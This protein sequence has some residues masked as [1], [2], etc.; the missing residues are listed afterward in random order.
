MRINEF[1]QWMMSQKRFYR[2][3]WD[4]YTELAIN[5]RILCLEKL[6]TI[7]NIDIDEKVENRLIAENFLN[8]IRDAHIEDLKHT[9]LSNAFRHYFKFATGKTIERIF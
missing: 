7:F 9:P 6:E 5:S 8:D 3:E 2:G 1:K 4:F